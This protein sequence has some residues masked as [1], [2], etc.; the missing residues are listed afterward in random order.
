MDHYID[1]F[2]FHL[3]TAKITVY[4]AQSLVYNQWRIIWSIT[5]YKSFCFSITNKNQINITRSSEPV[6]QP[7]TN[8]MDHYIDPFVFQLQTRTKL[9]KNQ[10]PNYTKLRACFTTSD[11]LYGPL[12]RSFCFS[13]TNKNQINQEPRTKLHEAQSLFYNQWRII[14]TII[15]ILLFFNYKQEPNSQ[16]TILRACFTTSYELYGPL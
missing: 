13:I 6:L 3:H 4:E 11:E 7:V 5:V 10:E 2:V 12:Y 16:Y 14:W 1:P 8:Y 9:T 15:S